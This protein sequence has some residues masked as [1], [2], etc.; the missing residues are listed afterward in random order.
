MKQRSMKENSWLERGGRICS[1]CLV[2]KGG[3]KEG[4]VWAWIASVNKLLVKQ[5]QQLGIPEK[6]VLKLKIPG[7][8]FIR[9]FL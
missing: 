5:M 7:A 6:N 9:T 2:R 3:G 1:V 4:T 8:V